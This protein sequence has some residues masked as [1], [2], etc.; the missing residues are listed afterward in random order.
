MFNLALETLLILIGLF[1]AGH[2]LLYKRDPRAALGWVALC[3]LFPGVGALLYWAFGVNRIRT[4]ARSWR[5]RRN[6]GRDFGAGRSPQTALPLFLEE[7]V[8]A[9]RKVSDH[10]TDRPLVGGNRIAVLHN[11]EEAYP[12]MLEAIGSARRSVYLSTYIFGADPTGKRFIEALA[13]ATAR[14]A[15]VRVLV[16]GLGELYSF[17]AAPRLLKKKGVR[18]ARF[19]PLS[20][21][22][23]L[24]LRNH[25]KLLVIDSS[26]GFTGGMNIGDR[27]LAAVPANPRRVVD[28]HFRVDGPVAAQMEET[29]LEDW[30]FV[31]GETGAP[32]Q[33]PLS[34]PGGGAFCR[35]VSDGPNDD[36]E[37][38]RWIIL[39]AL[40]AAQSRV[41]VMTPYFIPDRALLSAFNTAALRGVLVEIILPERNNLPYVAW[42]AQAL[43]WELLSHG[44]QVYYQPPPFVHSKLL[45]VDGVYT[46]VGSSN[47]DPRSL[48]LN[49]EF[50]LEI[51][52][53]DIAATLA[54]HFD[55]VRKRSRRITLA[56]MD[57]RPLPIK[58]RDGAA[59]LFSPYL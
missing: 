52:D 42:A 46:L 24:N 41:R 5:R 19:L 44:V 16:D 35:G 31:T 26:A 56:E 34:S 13:A 28:L 2:A 38:L 37:K 9:I 54:D 36:F 50:N 45:L 59:K 33:A 51:Y 1:S 32:P 49:F 6:W 4:R 3:L 30:R 55:A 12:A 8:S 39:G 11:G 10:V 21:G 47:L 23:R 40:S 48:R 20:R 57:G 43:L 14:G 22:L 18:V 58:L 29:F 25:R 15:D 53:P 27:H 17:P 7:K